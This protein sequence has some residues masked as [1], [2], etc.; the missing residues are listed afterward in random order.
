METQLN[1]EKAIKLEAE[2]RSH[3]TPEQDEQFASLLDQLRELGETHPLGI[4]TASVAMSIAA[5]EFVERVD[6]LKQ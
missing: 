5:T 2:F 3:L 6:K 1:R 4:F